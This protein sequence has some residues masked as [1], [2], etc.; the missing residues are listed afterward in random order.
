MITG[1]VDP[2]QLLAS[3]IPEQMAVVIIPA[4]N[5]Y[6]PYP[7]LW[8]IVMLSFGCGI[9]LGYRRSDI[10]KRLHTKLLTYLI[11]RI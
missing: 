1:P 8:L 7:V 10:W 5:F 9:Y 6:C 11:C 3:P 4:T 2:G